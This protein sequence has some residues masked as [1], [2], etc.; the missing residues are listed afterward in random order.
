VDVVVITVKVPAHAQLV[1]AAL[2]AGKHV[3]CEW[4]LARTTEEA[5][6]LVALARAAGVRHTIGLQARHAPVDHGLGASRH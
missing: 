1:Q 2:A 6:S 4:P 5:E 3:Y